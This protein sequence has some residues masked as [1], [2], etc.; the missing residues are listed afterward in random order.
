MKL[1]L[2]SHHSTTSNYWSAIPQLSTQTTILQARSPTYHERQMAKDYR[3][4]AMKGIQCMHRTQNWCLPTRITGSGGLNG[5]AVRVEDRVCS[6]QFCWHLHHQ[7]HPFDPAIVH[8]TIFLFVAWEEGNKPWN[9][10]RR[11]T[12]YQVT[13]FSSLSKQKKEKPTKQAEN[14]KESQPKSLNFQG[15]HATRGFAGKR[16]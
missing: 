6:M 1:H 9:V 12:V 2:S 3:S 15:I 10:K 13:P 16:K 5:Y 8:I 11:W 4:I 14:G 7:W